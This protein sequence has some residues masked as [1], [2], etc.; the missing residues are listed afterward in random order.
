V[1]SSSP[2]VSQVETQEHGACSLS[3]LPLPPPCCMLCAVCCLVSAPCC[4]LPA[5][6]GLLIEAHTSAHIPGNPAE[7]SEGFGGALRKVRQLS[8]HKIVIYMS[9][10]MSHSLC[11]CVSVS[12][13]VCACALA[14]TVEAVSVSCP[15]PFAALF[16]QVTHFSAS[17]TPSKTAPRSRLSAVCFLLLSAFCFLLS[18]VY[19]LL[20]AVCVVCCLC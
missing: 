1:Q 4:L 19:C 6:C 2:L 14:A 5:V 20:S 7:W 12:L 18:P 3:L 10:C 16:C 13:S 11:A 8:L 15:R 17:L 9:A